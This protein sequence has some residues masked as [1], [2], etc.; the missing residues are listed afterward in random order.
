MQANM[1]YTYLYTVNSSHIHMYINN[2]VCGVLMVVHLKIDIR[3]APLIPN[4]ISSLVSYNNT[5]ICNQSGGYW[6]S[7]LQTL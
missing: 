5:V 6:L 3:N 1:H 4:S 2:I 7:I